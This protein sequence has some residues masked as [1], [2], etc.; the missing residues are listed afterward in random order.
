M[1]RRGEARPGEG[2]NGSMVAVP[3][4]EAGRGAAWQG[5]AGPGMARQGKGRAVF[6]PAFFYWCYI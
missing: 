3:R 4:I 2:A 5:K 1:A 6:R